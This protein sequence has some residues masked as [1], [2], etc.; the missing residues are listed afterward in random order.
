MSTDSKK[1]SSPTVL[2]Q[3][4]FLVI[5]ILTT[6]YFYL[7]SQQGWDAAL[8]GSVAGVVTSLIALLGLL[9]A[10]DEYTDRIRRQR[11]LISHSKKKGDAKLG[12]NEDA[13]EVGLLGNQGIILGRIGKKIYRYAGEAAVIVA[14]RPGSWKGVAFVI[15]NLLEAPRPTKDNFQSYITIDIS[16]E[17]YS[18]CSR[19]LRE[20]GYRVVVIASEATRLSEE[21]GI[22]IESICHNPAGY[23]NALDPNVI[24]DVETFVHL[25]HPGVEPSKQNGTTQ[26]FDDLAR[27]I[28]ATCILWLLL[29]YDEVTLPGLR[30]CVMSSN[31]EL[32]MLLES[33][34]ES[35]AFGGALSESAS[36]VL[37]LM[38]NSPEE[39]SG[40]ITTATRSVKLFSAGGNV[41]KIVSRDGFRWSELK[42]EPIAVFI[43]V[44]PERLKSQAQFLSLVISASAEALAR[45]RS[46]QRVI[47]L[48]DEVGNFYLPNLMQI[49]SLYRK[50]GLQVILVLQQLESQLARIYGKDAAREIQGNCEVIMALSMTELD[51]L[52][53]LSELAG[54]ETVF[55]GSHTIRETDSGKPEVSYSGSYQGQPVLR[56]DAIRRLEK[57]QG[58]VLYANA[59]PFIVE[60]MNYLEDPQILSHADPNP[61]YKKNEGAL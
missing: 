41:G 34:S 24:E 15:R 17:L 13:K 36:S 56:S 23:L 38:A 5:A 49:V 47:Y 21:L 29:R 39:F 8:I 26:H 44:P 9:N 3:L 43:I 14:G 40:A 59:P 61:F 57:H 18:V 12:D 27:L 4:I 50:Y 31:D 35:D 11:R 19:R 20:L 1:Q 37:S 33:T 45:E 54:Q 10:I 53:R 48:L 55:D 7:L 25:L 22:P 51:D 52:K 32:H 2:G 58:L 46:N 6:R 28:L 60:L 16:G 30:R 42:K